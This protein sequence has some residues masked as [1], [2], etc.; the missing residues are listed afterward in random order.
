[1]GQTPD[2]FNFLNSL[3]LVNGAAIKGKGAVT[4]SDG[5]SLGVTG[6]LIYYHSVSKQT[7]TQSWGLSSRVS[8]AGGPAGCNETLRPH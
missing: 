5:L 8:P 4:G 3:D 6:S 1:M 7:A 2:G